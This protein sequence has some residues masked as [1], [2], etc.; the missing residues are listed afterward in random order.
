MKTTPSSAKLLSFILSLLLFGSSFLSCSQPAAEEAGTSEG[1]PSSAENPPAAEE[2]PE[3]EP[4]PF[5]LL[6]AKD[7]EGRTYTM[8]SRALYISDQ[9]T[10][11]LTGEAFND[12]VFDR[13]TAVEDKYNVT[14][15]ATPINGE[16]GDRTSFLNAVRSSVQAGDGAY[17]LIE[18]YAATIGDGFADHL[19]YNLNDVPGLQLEQGWWSSLVRDELTVNGRLFAVTGD[20]AVSLWKNMQVIFFN[21]DMM[22]EY[23]LDSPYSLVL[24]GKWTLDAYLAMIADKAIDLDGN[25]T[26]NEADRYGALYYDTLAFDNLHNAFGVPMTARDADGA[27]TLSLFNDMTVFIAEIT[28]NMAYE[29]P[30]IRFTGGTVG[31]TRTKS[32]Q[33]FTEGAALF[34]TSVLEDAEV[35]RDM[36][37]DFGIL[38]PPK[39][40]EAQE[41]YYTT[42]RDG[43]S[44]FVIPVD[45][46]DVEF[47]GT[48][49]EA[50]CVAGNRKVI[51][52]YYD[53]VL[54]TKTA[55]DEE[56]GAMLDLIR[57]GLVLDFAAEYAVQTN[58]AGFIIRDCIEG[59]KE[60]ASF[61]KGSEKAWNKMFEKFLEPYYD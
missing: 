12:A 24:E 41:H 9:W 3:P 46:K 14:V 21:K 13:N 60:L 18:G 38:P 16:W 28:T 5:D 32:V 50:L 15:A 29:N 6:P 22:K 47:A 49:T 42:S 44:M 4:D 2:A 43:R 30:D 56:S 20:I 52:V 1:S 10:E 61:F 54:K 25:G 59:K 8:L 19:Y 35:M 53:T 17:D 39:Y 45:V 36:T 57:D 26:M 23:G 51:P 48:I 37:A 33:Q 55:R 7:Y 11:G 27:V 34:F 31:D 40:D 58:R